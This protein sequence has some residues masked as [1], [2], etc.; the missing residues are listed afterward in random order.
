MRLSKNESADLWRAEKEEN[1]LVIKQKRRE[2]M[3]AI[4][5]TYLSKGTL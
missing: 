3:K 1:P 5:D 4:I 2:L